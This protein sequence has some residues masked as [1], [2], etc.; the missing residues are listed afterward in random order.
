M[1]AGTS[2]GCWP[3]RPRRS[4]RGCCA[5]GGAARSARQPPTTCCSTSRPARCATR[6]DGQDRLVTEAPGELDPG[7]WPAIGVCISA[8]F[9]TLLDVSIV[10]VALP[11]ISRGIGAG[12]SELQWVV[13]GYALAFGMVPIIAGRLGDDR[14]RKRM[15]L[16]GI[17][18]FVAFSA[19]VGLAPT[20]GI[21][22]AGRVLQGLAGGLL[23]PQVSGLVQQMFPPVERGKAFG[24]LGAAV[25]IGTAAG[26]VIGGAIIALGGED[27]G[28]RP[29]FLVKR[30]VGLASLIL[31]ARLLPSPAPRTETRRLDLPG[32]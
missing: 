1:P 18:S 21:L 2:G 29:C 30:P 19:M 27:F 22:I 16:I 20:P 12:P 6:N 5:P 14:G 25:G 8:L 24:A 11:S 17:A 13:S 10:N 23:N 31:C 26:P 4:G 32:V 15:L 28:W 9:I 3:G 7:R